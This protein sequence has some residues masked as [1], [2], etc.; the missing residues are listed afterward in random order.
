MTYPEIINKLLN[1]DESILENLKLELILKPPS[2]QPIKFL[3]PPTEGVETERALCMF[4]NE[5]QFYESI[6]AKE[7][8]ESI[9]VNFDNIKE[10]R[11]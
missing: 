6:M 2:A 9:E 3:D 10:E 1:N 7:S 8:F 5:S 11:D 4:T